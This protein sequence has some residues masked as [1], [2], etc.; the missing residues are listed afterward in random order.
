MQIMPIHL[1][2]FSFE[3][4]WLNL[5]QPNIVGIYCLLSKLCPVTSLS[6]Q[7]GYH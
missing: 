4:T 7:D 6:I 1:Q 5:N 3:T 2:I